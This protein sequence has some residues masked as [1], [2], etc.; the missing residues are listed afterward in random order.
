M[1]VVITF[2]EKDWSRVNLWFSRAFPNADDHDP[3]R[4]NK[5]NCL[6]PEEDVDTLAKIECFYQASEDADPA[7]HAEYT[8]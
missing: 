7:N 4:R 6:A 2:T 3:F 1:K 8:M 5:G